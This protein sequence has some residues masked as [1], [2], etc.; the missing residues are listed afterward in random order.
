MYDIFDVLLEGNDMPVLESA[1]PGKKFE[2]EYEGRVYLRYPV[3]TSTIMKGDDVIEVFEKEAG[4]FL[5]EKDIVLIAESVVAISQGRAY[6]FDEI[7]FGFWAKHLSKMVTRTPAGIGL[8][9]PQTMQLAIN[10]VGLWRILLAAFISAL[11]RPFGI[12]GMFYRVAGSRA[13]AV[14]GPTE[15]T[16]PP[17][18]SFASLSPKDPNEFVAR[19]EKHFSDKKI[20][21]AVIDANDLGVNILGFSSKWLKSFAALMASDNPLGQ[22]EESTPFLVVR[23]K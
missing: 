13:R 5:K 1:H 22:G 21:C 19:F 10:E 16:L 15:G 7:E 14:D 3:K 23:G 2:R 6:K 18:N 20:Q 9:T 17:Y 4:S 8:G 12:R 11:T